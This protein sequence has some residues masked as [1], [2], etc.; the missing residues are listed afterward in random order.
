MEYLEFH[1]T[2]ADIPLDTI[3]AAWE[4]STGWNGSGL[5]QKI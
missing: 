4:R 3:V 5:D 1:G 2:Y